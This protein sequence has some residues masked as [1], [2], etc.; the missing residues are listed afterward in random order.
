MAMTERVKEAV[1][2]FFDCEFELFVEF[3]GLIRLVRLY[4]LS[5]VDSANWTRAK[6]KGGVAA[7]QQVQT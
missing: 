2:E 3:T 7:G 4:P 1:E 6:Y 5:L